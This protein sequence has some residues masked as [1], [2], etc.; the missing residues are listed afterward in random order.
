MFTLLLCV[1]KCLKFHIFCPKDWKTEWESVIKAAS[2]IPRNT[3]AMQY[4]T[5]EGIHLYTLANI[6]RR[7]IIL[8]ADNTAR[9]VYGH[10]M[11]ENRLVGIYLPLEWSKD[12]V[13]RNPIVIGYNLSHFAPLVSQQA[14]PDGRAIDGEYVVP[15]VTHQFEQ[16]TPHF[17]LAN[18][19]EIAHELIS[20]YLKTKNIPMT[21]SDSVL[22]IPV[23]KVEYVAIHDRLDV[24]RAHREEC[25]QIYT[26]WSQREL[27][28]TVNNENQ[29]F[30]GEVMRPVQPSNEMMV[31]NE[32]RVVT[33][34]SLPLSE[35]EP[36][37]NA[38]NKCI[39]NGCQMYGSRDFGG[40]CSECFRKYTIEFQKQERAIQAMNMT[41]NAEPTA[42]PSS[43][44]SQT[45]YTD[46]SIM[47]ENCQNNCGNKCSVNTYPYCHE[48][49][50]PEAAGTPIPT[51]SPTNLIPNGICQNRA[52]IP[53]S[54]ASRVL[55]A[56]SIPVENENRAE[57]IDDKTLFGEGG[58]PGRRQRPLS[59]GNDL[60]S[61]ELRSPE[62]SSSTCSTPSCENPITPRTKN[63]C[64]AC[65]IKNVISDEFH[66]QESY[67]EPS[68]QTYI[69][70]V[71]KPR[72]AS[73]SVD[74][75][76]PRNPP[77][78][79]PPRQS[80]RPSLAKVPPLTPLGNQGRCR[81]PGCQN[82]GFDHQNNMC[83][84]CW[85]RH[86]QT[87]Q[88]AEGG[89]NGNKETYERN[90]KLCSTPGCQGLRMENPHNLC[91][92]CL[93]RGQ[94]LFLPKDVKPPPDLKDLKES[95]TPMA[96]SELPQPTVVTSSKDK[97]KCASPICGNLIYPPKAL[98][99]RC[100]MILQRNYAEEPNDPQR[101]RSLEIQREIPG[102]N[103]LMQI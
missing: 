72:N 67:E 103:T 74:P 12:K 85:N 61:P 52:A 44:P 21:S 9:S 68:S 33:S 34:H 25:D 81:T 55:E 59:L 40:M 30:Q 26:M 84:H 48:C 11:Q 96:T 24:V 47:G 92:F 87:F 93:Q 18:E 28:T 27:Q 73:E 95:A 58:S 32:I 4:E 45:R 42:P 78:M 63:R 86:L 1:L 23:A 89:Q 39:A 91:M 76:T 7:P 60:R 101:S 70:S 8:L 54:Q 36:Q 98:C 31:N 14:N 88:G 62:L 83:D 5:L 50:R 15:L 37:P 79:L 80:D 10:S 43:M 97:V 19:E 65:Y 35:H 100:T 56:S 49:Y 77:E 75:N 46:L 57:P 17:L 16:L 13:C 38:T 22:Q 82:F 3:G 66:I 94:P 20:Q 53:I 99:D 2:D 69:I 41:P 102:K 6:L 64:S 90:K 29:T 71:G 51:V